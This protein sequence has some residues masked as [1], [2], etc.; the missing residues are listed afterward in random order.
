MEEVEL[1]EVPSVLQALEGL[2]RAVLA[3]N[4]I[5]QKMLEVQWK[6]LAA[7]N[8]TN[9]QL[10]VAIRRQ[11]VLPPTPPPPSWNRYNRSY[12]N[13]HLLLYHVSCEYG[14]SQSFQGLE[15]ERSSSGNIC[16]RISSSISPSP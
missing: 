11:K 1:E 6:M 15:T 7:V 16:S 4:V 10:E 13:Q 9:D 3:G 14:S 5:Q 8:K 2:T 12:N